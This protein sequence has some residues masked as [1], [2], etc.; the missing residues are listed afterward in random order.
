MDLS[1]EEQLQL[2]ME[3]PKNIQQISNP[4][5]EAQL[6]AVKADPKAVELIEMPTLEALMVAAKS[7]VTVSIGRVTDKNYM[8][9]PGDI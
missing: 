5:G 2:V 4:C 1:R 9:G 3:N 7:G 8:P 6:A